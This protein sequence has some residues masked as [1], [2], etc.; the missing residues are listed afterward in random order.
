M[1]D[2]V[3][4]SNAQDVVNVNNKF[5]AY[6]VGPIQGHVH[7]GSDS[8]QI[9]VGDLMGYYNPIVTYT[10]AIA[11]TA[12]INLSQSNVNHITM[13]AGNVTL[14]ISGARAGQCF[15]VRILQD[16]VGSRT[17]TWFSTIK[18]AGGSPPTLTTTANKA[19]TFGFEITSTN[20]TGTTTY[21]GFIVGQNI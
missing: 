7:N 18:W 6:S 3:S 11:G 9:S 5:A 19:D 4:Q 8:P 1:D 12:I 20:Q 2:F 15:I 13:P 16:S 21:D 14:A 10:P 17:V